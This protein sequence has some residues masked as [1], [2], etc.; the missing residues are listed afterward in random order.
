MDHALM[1]LSVFERP[2]VFACSPH[3]HNRL[4]YEQL[5]RQQ[6]GN[7]QPYGAI[8]DP[9]F[10]YSIH[11]EQRNSGGKVEAQIRM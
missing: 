7:W 9:R 5:T 6:P 3:M 11:Y 4:L 2:R 1:H 10:P 8:G